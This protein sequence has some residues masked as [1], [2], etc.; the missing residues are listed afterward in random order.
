MALWLKQST[1]VTV[2]LGPFVDSGDGVS[3]ETSLTISQGDVRL[4]KNGGDIAQKHDDTALAHD[5]LGLYDCELDA[6]DTNTLGILRLDIQESGA[7][8]VW[9]EFMVLPANVYDSLVA[10]SDELLVETNTIAADAITA[11]AIKSDAVTELQNGLAAATDLALVGADT[12]AIKA[13]TDNLPALPA[14][15]GD[16]PTV[17]E[18]ATAVWQSLV[19]THKAVAGSAAAVLNGIWRVAGFGLCVRDRTLTTITVYDGAADTDAELLVQVGAEDG[20]EAS[21]T[22]DTSGGE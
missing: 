1:A 15:T 4:S 19:T 5:E 17:S 18:I 21:W 10:G 9:A 6:T 11:A 22:P 20:N 3:A 13:K 7:L 12:S 8:P 14:A 2:K 16:I